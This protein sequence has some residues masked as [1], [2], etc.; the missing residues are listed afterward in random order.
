LFYGKE[1]LI[2]RPAEGQGG[3]IKIIAESDGLTPA[4]VTVE[5]K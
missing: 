2:I 3:I 5:S 4:E 1:T